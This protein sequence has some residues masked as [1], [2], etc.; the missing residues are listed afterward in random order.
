VGSLAGQIDATLSSLVEPG[1]EVALLDLPGYPNVGDSAIWLGELAWLAANGSEVRFVASHRSYCRTA[2]RR[3]IGGKTIL[4]S[5]GG[6]LGDAYPWHQHLRERVIADFPANRI[7]Q[8]PQSA[9]F[10][11]KAER[12]RAASAMRAHPGLTILARDQPT[13][14]V[15]SD[16]AED[17]R[18]CP[19]MA[20]CLGALPAPA[21]PQGTDGVVAL[22]RTDSQSCVPGRSLGTVRVEDWA[23]A[24]GPADGR[25]L[26][27]A[28]KPLEHLSGRLSPVALM[29]EGGISRAYRRHARVRLRAGIRLLAGG[30][31][32]ITDRLHAAILAVLLGI[33]V[34]MIDIANGKLGAFHSAWLRDY[35]GCRM[36]SPATAVEIA[37]AMS[38][39]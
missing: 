26:R 21:A 8:L 5:G 35:P 28:I 31:A 36:A 29:A 32:V 19:D 37:V 39:D 4:L 18:L 23:T 7:V 38:S 6:N 25:L 16:L 2:A 34:V 11:C 9:S 17:V 13:V 3:R 22:L 15:C 12:R 20:F 33:P 27:T 14:E 24:R 1:E 10:R 30:G